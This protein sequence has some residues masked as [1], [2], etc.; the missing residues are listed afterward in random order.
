MIEKRAPHKSRYALETLVGCMVARACVNYTT[1]SS[2][3]GQFAILLFEMFGAVVD[4]VFFQLLLLLC[5]S[6][7]KLMMVNDSNDFDLLVFLFFLDHSIS[8]SLPTC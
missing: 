5:L 3:N 4:A 8:L 2:W 6:C 1:T 7:V